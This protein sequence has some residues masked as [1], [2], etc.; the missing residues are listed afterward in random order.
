MYNTKTKELERFEP[1]GFISLGCLNPPGL[2]N[3]LADLFNKNVK[4]DMVKQVFAPLSFSPAISFQNIQHKQEISQ[5]KSSDPKG[6]CVAWS[7]WYADTRLSNPNKSRIEV[8]N[9]A[10]ENLKKSPFSFTQFIR[11]YSAFL[12]TVSQQ[13][14]QGNNPGKVF[15]MHI[16]PYT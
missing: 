16:Q 12:G 3:K 15:A 14:K 5:R 10:L 8:V 6:F 2:E 7:A 13:I 9:M 11:S 4:K 1:H